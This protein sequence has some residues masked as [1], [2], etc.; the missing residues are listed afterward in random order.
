MFLKL[1]FWECWGF[2]LFFCLLVCGLFV[3]LF[4]KVGQQTDCSCPSSGFP[5]RFSPFLSHDYNDLLNS[6]GKKAF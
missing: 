4:F 6:A 2:F 3:W 5:S 1:G